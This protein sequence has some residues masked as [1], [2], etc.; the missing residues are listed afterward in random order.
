MSESIREKTV[1]DLA[2]EYGLADEAMLQTFSKVGGLLREAFGSCDSGIGMG[3]ADF[4]IRD[5]DVEYRLH[6]KPSR[7]F[8]VPS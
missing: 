4:H 8:K 6:M 3:G 7:F 2:R 1:A 5:G